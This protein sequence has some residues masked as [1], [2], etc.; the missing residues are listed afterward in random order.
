MR[1]VDVD[2]GS[3]QAGPAKELALGQPVGLHVAVV[4]EVVLREI[5]EYGHTH[6]AAGQ[7]LGRAVPVTV[8]DSVE[9]ALDQALGL[10]GAQALVL[11]TGSIFVAAGIREVWRERENPHA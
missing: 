3:L 4:V 11:A 6:A 1:I 8:T 2:H 10:A 7:A 9:A 5:G